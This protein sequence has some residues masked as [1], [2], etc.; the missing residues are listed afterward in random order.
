ML[1]VVDEFAGIAC[2][3]FTVY[4]GEFEIL[5]VVSHSYDSSNVTSVGDTRES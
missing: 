2:N 5:D 1:I 3:G 4:V